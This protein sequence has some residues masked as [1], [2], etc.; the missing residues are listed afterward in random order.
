M[1]LKNIKI[2][3]FIVVELLKK[4]P[5]IE[6]KIDLTC[7]ENSNKKNITL[8]KAS[9]SFREE[10]HVCSKLL[11]IENNIFETESRM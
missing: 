3:N 4:L 11:K 8:K 5:L 7:S 6:R 10:C 1:Q 2:E 9:S